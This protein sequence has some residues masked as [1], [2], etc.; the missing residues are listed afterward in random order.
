MRMYSSLDDLARASFASNAAAISSSHSV[1]RYQLSSRGGRTRAGRRTS[2]ASCTS[3]GLGT[4]SSSMPWK[5]TGVSVAAEIA[6]VPPK[7]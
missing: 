3:S 4:T 7:H 1:E 5:G 6:G 2:P